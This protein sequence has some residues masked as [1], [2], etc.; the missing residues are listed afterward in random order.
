MLVA[1]LSL[2]LHT[3]NDKTTDWPCFLGPNRTGAVSGEGVDLDWSDADPEVLWDLEIGAGY[4]GVAVRDGEVYLLDREAGEADVFRVFD[5]ASGEELWS[6][7]YEA[8]GRLSFAGSRTV[9]AATDEFVITCGG[10]GHVTAYDRKDRSLAWQVHLEE[11]YGGVLPMFGWSCS[12]LVV[13]DLVIVSPLGEEVGL[14]A[15]DIETGEERWVTPGLGYSHSTPVLLEFFGQQQILFCSTIEQGTGQNQSA[16]MRIWS[17]DVAT[18]EPLWQHDLELSR[19]PIPGPIKID[20]NRL[21]VTGGYRGGSSMVSI[22]KKGDD[23][24][25]ADIF[26]IER[27]S[28]THFPLLHGEHVY[29]VVNENW[30]HDRPLRKEGGLLCLDLEGNEVWRTGEDPFFGR[31][32]AILVGDDLLIQDGFNGVL[33]VVAATPKGFELK[34]EFNVFG[35]EDGRRD[36]Q[37]WA[38]MALAGNRLLMRS[39]DRLACVSL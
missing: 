37:M 13:D 21:F 23:Y 31:G 19:L 12:P 11:D 33:R 35:T 9:P 25:L 16:P 26:H 8:P 29:V 15:L 5:L 28:Q 27:G 34:G 3:P 10:F 1:L 7:A 4:G 24:V 18:G 38:P 6:D 22:E 30:N 20:E 36:L 2:A 39:Q 17:F 32:H 14:V